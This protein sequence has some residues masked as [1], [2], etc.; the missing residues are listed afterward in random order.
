MA[1]R[2]DPAF[3]AAI[4]A[5]DLVVADGIGV[6]LAG[7]LLGADRARGLGRVTGIEV[8]EW[9]AAVSGPLAAPLFLLGGGPGVAAEA[10]AALRR[11]HPSARIAGEWADGSPQAADDGARARPDRGVG[12]AGRPRRLRRAGAG[13]VDLAQ[14][15]RAGGRRGPTGDRSRRCLR[16]SG[17][18]DAASAG[19]H[20]PARAGVAVP[21][22]A[23]ATALAAAIGLASLRRADLAGVALAARQSAATSG[24]PERGRSRAGAHLPGVGAREGDGAASPRSA[25]HVPA[26]ANRRPQS[27]P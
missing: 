11:R 1:A 19:L 22:G 6:L 10:A 16:L 8:V 25:G 5:A 23:S 9:L 13:G 7:R 20:A 2:R 26:T 14:P 4:A 21:A 15:R 12:G 27:D 17:R 3:A 18:T 24:A